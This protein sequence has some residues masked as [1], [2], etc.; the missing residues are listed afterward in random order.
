MKNTCKAIKLAPNSKTSTSAGCI[1]LNGFITSISMACFGVFLLLG[2]PLPTVAQLVNTSSNISNP[3]I[4]EGGVVEDVVFTWVN[5]NSYFDIAIFGF[6]AALT[7]Q[8]AEPDD[9]G[10]IRI[11]EGSAEFPFHW[12]VYPTFQPSFPPVII[13]HPGDSFQDEIVFW[14]SDTSSSVDSDDPPWRIA[15]TATLVDT[16]QYSDTDII[17]GAYDTN[18]VSSPITIY[19][20]EAPEPNS[21]ALVGLGAV[22]LIISRAA[23]GRVK[24]PTIR[25]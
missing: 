8:W 1:G 14:A 12:V 19:L 24:L 25:K 11:G 16:I 20:I 5:K 22:A 7:E 15:E 2:T 21:L 13:L 10:V 23:S 18:S 3:Y 17:H 4:R 9:H 6:S